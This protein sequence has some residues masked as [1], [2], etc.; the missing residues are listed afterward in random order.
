MNSTMQTGLARTFRRLGWLGFW[1]QIGIVA[2]SAGLM[3]YAFIFDRQGGFGT[4][5]QLAL[6]E[7]M[8]LAGFLILIFTTIWFYRYTRLAARIADPER[9]PSARAIQRSAWIGV[10]SATTN[11]VFSLLVILFEIVQLFVYFLR[12]PQAGVPVVQ[13]TG[14]P[15]SWVSAGDILSLMVLILTMVVEVVMVVFSLWL[16]YRAMAVS[17][18]FP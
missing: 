4:R 3:G 10:L 9:R 6:I 11:V 8:S 5:G 12:A 16:L 17:A 15:A 7:Y 18:E 14:G 13:T 1:V 2:I